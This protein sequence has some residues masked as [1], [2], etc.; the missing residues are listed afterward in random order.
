M[1]REDSSSLPEPPSRGKARG[2]QRR[3]AKQPLSV[4]RIVDKA[5]EVMAAE[6]FDAVTMRRL[7]QELGTGPASL[8]AHV[9]SKRELDQLIVDRIAAEVTVPD[10]DPERWQEQVKECARGLATAMRRHPG[11]ARAAMANVP[12]GENALRTTDSLLAIMLAGGLQEQVAA[13]ACDLLPLYVT[14]II[15]EESL[16]LQGDP[17]EAEEFAIRLREYFE[18]VP[19]DRFPHLASS[20]VALTAG[21]GD[22]RFEF[23][24]SVLVAGL[25]AVSRSWPTSKRA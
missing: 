6:G 9:D 5:F 8:Y 24:L 13:W 14:A 19:A 17:K 3:R 4:E 10:A 22:D 1:S 15:F 16:Y 23:G 18:S 11:S 12:T 7:A 25:D 20:A 21:E 2:R